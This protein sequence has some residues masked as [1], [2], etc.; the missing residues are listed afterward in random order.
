MKTQKK[1]ENFSR[2]ALLKLI[3]SDKINSPVSSRDDGDGARDDA[4]E[5]LRKKI[6]SFL[7][8]QHIEKVFASRPKKVL[9]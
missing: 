2:F 1:P 3:F 8:L 4:D 6:P 7:Y 5:L 9:C